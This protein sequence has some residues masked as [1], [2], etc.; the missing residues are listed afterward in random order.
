[1]KFMRHKN[2][3]PEYL[4]LNGFLINTEPYLK[5][6]YFVSSVLINIKIWQGLAK[7]LKS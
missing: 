6:H 2:R 3:F 7:L 1:M 5:K 4:I